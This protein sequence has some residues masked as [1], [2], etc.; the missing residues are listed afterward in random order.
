MENNEKNR[1]FEKKVYF[2]GKNM[3]SIKF[4]KFV[5]KIV[6]KKC[7]FIKKNMFLKKYE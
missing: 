5:K 6:D 1:K 2:Y 3:F 7:N 4:E